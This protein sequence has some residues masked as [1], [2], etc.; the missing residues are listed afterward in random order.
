MLRDDEQRK[1]DFECQGVR[2]FELSLQLASCDLFLWLTNVALRV[3]F[4]R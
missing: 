1:N 3:D 4:V 2:S